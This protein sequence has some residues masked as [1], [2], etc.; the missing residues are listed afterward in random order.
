MDDAVAMPAAPFVAS[1]PLR[2]RGI[3][4]SLA[5]LHLEGSECCLVHVDNPL[6]VEKRTYVNPLVR[7]GYNGDAYN[8]VHPQELLLSSWQI[9]K[10]LW[11][12]R[13]LRWVWSPRFKEWK[14]H[15]QVTKWSSVSKQH[16]AGEICL[17]NEMQVLIE[18]GWAHV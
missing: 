4:D 13:F 2:F 10:A 7:V 12:N 17:I 6:R 3:P 15:K 5:S 14:V 16:E 1:P 9:F 11:V 8:A 18:N